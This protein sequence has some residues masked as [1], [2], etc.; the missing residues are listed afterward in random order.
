MT[1]KEFIRVLEVMGYV[2][3]IEGNRIAIVND[4]GVNLGLIKSIP[5]RVSFN[6]SGSLW[7]DI[8]SIPSGV[9]FNN[10]GNVYLYSLRSIPPGVEFNNSGDVFFN[11]LDT[12]SSDVFKID[13]ISPVRVLNVM[14]KRL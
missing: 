9:E 2:Y 14:S 1:R 8:K 5:P 13:G 6:N 10:G 12:T 3:K 7:L 4:G 11:G